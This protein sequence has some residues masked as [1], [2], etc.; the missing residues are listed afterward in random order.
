MKQLDQ[1]REEVDM[2]DDQILCLLAKRIDIIKQIALEKKHNQLPLLDRDREDKMKE[3]WMDKSKKY[4][5]NQTSIKKIF[6]EIVQM[7][8]NTQYDLIK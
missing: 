8:K 7:S 3:Y 4:N 2:I 6:D 5:M 1:L